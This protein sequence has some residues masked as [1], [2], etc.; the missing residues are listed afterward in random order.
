MNAGS[1][2]NRTILNG[3]RQTWVEKLYNSAIFRSSLAHLIAIND[4]VTATAVLVTAIFIHSERMV[5][6]HKQNNDGLI[7]M[8]NRVVQRLPPKN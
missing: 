2:R 5:D 8:I 3:C 4:W 1:L 7:E 6:M